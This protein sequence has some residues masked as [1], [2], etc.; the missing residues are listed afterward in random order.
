M[1]DFSERKEG[2]F[3]LIGA[4]RAEQS[5]RRGCGCLG[6]R[7]WVWGEDTGSEKRGGIDRQLLPLPCRNVPN[8]LL[9]RGSR[10]TG[11][12]PD[13]TLRDHAKQKQRERECGSRVS[14]QCRARSDIL[15]GALPQPLPLGGVE[16]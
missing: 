9:W 11:L 15:L 3:F 10:A 5:T 1:S 13:A 7:L 12:R 6:S 8:E 2:P 16:Q 4:D 14:L